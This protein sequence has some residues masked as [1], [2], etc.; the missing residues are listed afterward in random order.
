MLSHDNLIWDARSMTSCFTFE[1]GNER[2]ITYLPLSHVAA[3]VSNKKKTPQ[4]KDH[5]DLT[6]KISRF[7]GDRYILS[8]TAKTHRLLR[9]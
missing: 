7:T 4:G 2:I 3:Q 1:D 6:L 5:N 8:F 9:K